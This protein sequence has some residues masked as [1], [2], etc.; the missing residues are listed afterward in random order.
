L[1]ELVCGVDE[2]GRGPV[3]GP[4]VVAGVAVDDIV[5]LRNLGVKDS[6]KLSPAQRERLAPEI[7]RLAVDW[8]IRAKSAAELDRLMEKQTLNEIEV[9]MY[10]EII[11]LLKPTHAYVDAVDVDEKRFA[12]DLMRRIPAGIAVVAEHKADAT[13]PH[14]GA[15]SILAKVLRD[16]EVQK[17]SKELGGNMGSGYPSDEVTIAFI[18]RFVKDHGRLPPHVRRQWKT[19]KDIWKRATG[20]DRY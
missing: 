17:I 14:V 12:A 9:D 15:A 16:T 19:A 10:A 20:L 2:A 8:K 18:E 1:T 4:L 3:I 5:A 13:Y 11:S 7:K 6:K